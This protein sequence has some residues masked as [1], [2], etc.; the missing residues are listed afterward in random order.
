[1][2][3]I[4][5]IRLI[6]ERT[7]SLLSTVYNSLGRKQSMGELEQAWLYFVGY[8]EGFQKLKYQIHPVGS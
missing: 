4:T 3:I 5:I 2:L 6:L 1:M 8:P 7:F